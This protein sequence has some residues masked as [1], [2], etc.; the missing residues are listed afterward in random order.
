MLALSEVPRYLKRLLRACLDRYGT[1]DLRVLAVFRVFF[2]LLLLS[3]LL[4]RLPDVPLFYSNDG[5]LSNHFALYA[6]IASPNASLLFAF[7]TPAEVW[8]AMALVGCSYV[9]LTVGFR[10]RAAQ[11]L[12]LVGFVSVNGR[13]LFLENRASWEIAAIAAWTALLPLGSRYSID[14]LRARRAPAKDTVQSVAVFG[15]VLQIAAVYGFNALNKTGATWM[16]GDAV[17]YVLWQNRVA[18]GLGAWVRETEPAWFSPLLSYGALTLEGAIALLIMSPVRQRESRVAAYLLAAALHIGMTLLWNLWPH[19]YANVVINLLFVPPGVLESV[20]RRLAR[21]R[22]WAGDRGWRLP[23]IPGLVAGERREELVSG[24]T[25]RITARRFGRGVREGLALLFLAA[26]V[27]RMA[28]DNAIVPERYRPKLVEWLDLPVR[29]LR[30]FQNWSMFGP[31]APLTDGTVVVDAVKANGQHVDP[32]TGS[33]PDFEAPLH[34]PWYQRQA[35][36]DY[37]RNIA[38]DENKPYRAELGAHLLRWHER[39]G[40]GV[41]ERIVSYEIYWVG[42]DAPP[43]GESGARNLSR[44][45]LHKGARRD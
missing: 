10:T 21:L 22:G 42:S 1:I 8:A 14:S 28:H 6:P 34:G 30:V 38:R 2:G 24:G 15:A 13:N 11:V 41:E 35:L 7:S 19:S 33:T 17:H 29:Y 12:A 23:R 43:P 18:T 40:R 44:R 45:L 39:E 16:S 4:R 20:A 9:A 26:V 27:Q 37:F 31:D 36:C 5:V 25:V 32:L 3:D